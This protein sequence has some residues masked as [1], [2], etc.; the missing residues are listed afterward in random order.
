MGPKP[1]PKHSIER[2]DCDGDYTPGNCVWATQKQQT[3]NTSRNIFVI[4]NGK[5]MAVTE[6]SE[7]SGIPREVI[8][9]RIK[10]GWAAEFLFMLLGMPVYGPTRPRKPRERKSV[11][12]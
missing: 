1:S 11:A 7:H 9:A 2:L 3:R 6:A 12:A 4:Y 5:R 10:K 8:Y